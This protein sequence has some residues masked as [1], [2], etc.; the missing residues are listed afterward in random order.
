MLVDHAID[1]EAV[2]TAFHGFSPPTFKLQ[3]KFPTF[4][5]EQERPCLT[6]ISL[7]PVSN[8]LTLEFTEFVRRQTA[9]WSVGAAGIQTLTLGT[10]LI[11]QLGILG[12][13]LLISLP[14]SEIIRYNSETS[15]TIDLN[16]DGTPTGFET[17]VLS[18]PGVHDI[19]GNVMCKNFPDDLYPLP[20]LNKPPAIL[21][22]PNELQI[23]EPSDTD[24]GFSAV[25][26]VRLTF[27]RRRRT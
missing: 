23:G 13:D 20:R 14:L 10:D 11:V 2:L 16:W 7:E 9:S 21:V 15:M 4:K 26:K 25:A 8:L 6:A 27:P 12:T 19:S 24:S 1:G 17:I 22:A 18:F 5:L 3:S